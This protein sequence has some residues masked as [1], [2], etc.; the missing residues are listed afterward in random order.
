MGLPIPI[1]DTVFNAI[2]KVA[3][4][5]WPDAAERERNKQA[6]QLGIMEYVMRENQ[7]LFGDPEGARELFKIELEAANT[8][9]FVTALQKLARPFTMYSMVCMYVCVKI[10]PL[11]GK[12][13]GVDVPVLDLN[14][15]DYYLIGTVFV[16]LFGARTIEKIT[17]KI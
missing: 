1:I 11:I 12:W 17:K 7:L 14:N 6:L 16:F 2:G 15:Y 5:I 4:K 9:R 3:D 13:A 8:P 10:A